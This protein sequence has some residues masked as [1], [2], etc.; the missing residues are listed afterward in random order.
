MISS[1]ENLARRLHKGQFRRDGKTPYITHPEAVASK[2]K[3][4][5]LV[6]IAWLH[7]ILEDTTVYVALTKLPN[8]N[9]L[10]YLERVKKNSLAVLVKIEDIKHNLSDDPT[11]NQKNK[12]LLALEVLDD[13]DK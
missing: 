13:K 3:H 11:P 9:Y 5:I 7:D 12:Y 10:Y 4:P 6:D 8:E 1:A 2:F